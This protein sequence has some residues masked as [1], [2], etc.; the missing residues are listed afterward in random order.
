MLLQTNKQVGY[1]SIDKPWLKYYSEKV[2]NTPLPQCSIYEYLWDCNKDH[3]DDYALNYF[4]NKITYQKLF[5]MIDDAAK[6]FVAIG[7][8]EKE[9]VPIISVSTVISVVCFYALNKI[10]AVSDFL[11]VLSEEHDFKALFDEA[12]AKT[13][14]TLDLFAP[15]VVGAAKNSSVERIITF[16][17]DQNMPSHIRLGYK[18]KTLG[19]LPK[20]SATTQLISWDK[21]IQKGGA[22]KI[23]SCIKN[24]NEICMLAHTGGTTGTPKAVRLDDRSMNAVA[25]QQRSVYEKLPE[26]DKKATFL[27]V[28][29]P[30]VVYGILTCTHMPLCMGWCVALI[31]KFEESEW[32]N[33]F[34]KYHFSYV[35]AVPSYVTCMIDN[36]KLQK[37]D[38]SDLKIIAAGGDGV[39]DTIENKMNEFLSNHGSTA[40][41][42]KGYGMTEVCA[43]GLITFPSCNKVGSV[44][45]PL[46]KNNLMV[47]DNELEKELSY[48]EIGEVCLQCPSRMQGYM[49]NDDETSLL[50]R[51]HKDGQEWLHTGDLGYIDEDGFLFLVGRMK[52]VIMT[53]GNGVTYKVFPNIPERILDSHELVLQSCI[54]G[55]LDGDNQVL[56]AYVVIADT[57]KEKEKVIEKEL[58]SL[59]DENLPSYSRPTFYVFC[60]SLPLTPAGKVDYM[61]LEQK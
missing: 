27:Q 26:Y 39:T 28:I 29:V 50:F 19:K 47:F 24:P 54:V 37:K 61:A 18:L 34:K 7:I 58:R 11:N 30:F 25:A 35:L 43:A 2:I 9:I 42:E 41:L 12:D 16:S 15:K 17:I 20:I 4:G 8:K 56:R 3:L 13:V 36:P 52:R 22:V 21:F 59:C 10:G 31:P 57:D 49:N 46:P 1:P 6:A 44:G 23:I 51:V 55:A 38:L 60:N 14:L 48:R 33:Y 32:H 5:A 40:R 53:T 45:I